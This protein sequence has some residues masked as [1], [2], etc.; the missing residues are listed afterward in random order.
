MLAGLG[1][2]HGAGLFQRLAAAAFVT[3]GAL[4]ME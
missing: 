4:V 3:P 2:R 1:A